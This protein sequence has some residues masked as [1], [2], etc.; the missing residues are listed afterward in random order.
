VRSQLNTEDQYIRKP[1]KNKLR[2]NCDDQVQVQTPKLLNELQQDCMRH[3]LKIS[4]TQDM[5]PQKP[6][7]EDLNGPVIVEENVD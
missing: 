1:P 3:H 5:S 4:V 2:I 6:L 7:L